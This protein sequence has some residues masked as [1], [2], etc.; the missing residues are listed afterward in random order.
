L[1]DNSGSMAGEKARAATEGVREMLMTC[2]A[3]G[4]QGPERS[5]F[6]LL[7]IRFG[8]HA[9]ID[10]ACDMTHVR[11][12]DPDKVEV[13]GD[14]GQTNLTEAL[15][16]AFSRLEPYL[17]ELQ[18]HPERTSHPLPLVLVFSDG[19]HNVGAPPQAAAAALKRLNLDGQPVLVAAAGVSIGSEKPDEALL[20]DIASP[21]CYFHITNAQA[22]SSFISS[23]GSSGASRPEDLAR[24]FAK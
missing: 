16:L 4:P 7:L 20:R 3:R 14:G 8:D 5:Y 21:E 10:S 19:F 2:Q 12:I 13:R 22:L 18:T 9:T 6:K 23:V 24:F 11:K 1:A 17:K 15:E